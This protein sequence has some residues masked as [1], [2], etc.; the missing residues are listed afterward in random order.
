MEELEEKS[1]IAIHHPDQ[2]HH[3]ALPPMHHRYSK[4]NNHLIYFRSIVFPLCTHLLHPARAPPNHRTHLCGAKFPIKSLNTE[5]EILSFF[6]LL[7][8]LPVLKNE[9]PSLS[10]ISCP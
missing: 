4:T 5:S 3:Q 7:R 10:H 6:Y 1:L 8:R 9:K 2:K